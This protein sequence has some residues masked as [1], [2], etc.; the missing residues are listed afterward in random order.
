MRFTELI[1]TGASISIIMNSVRMKLRLL[2]TLWKGGGLRGV[3]AS[4][5]HAVGVVSVS[6][7]MELILEGIFDVL[8]NCTHDV[9][10]G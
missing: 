2:G 7:T 4:V 3:N 9:I 5:I 10:L 1:D 8:S 6:I